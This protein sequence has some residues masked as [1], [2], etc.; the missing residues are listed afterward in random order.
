MH[1]KLGRV[2]HLS[3]PPDDLVARLSSTPALTRDAIQSNASRRADPASGIVCGV[4]RVPRVAPRVPMRADPVPVI[5][6]LTGGFGAEIAALVADEAFL[7]LDAPIARLTMRCSMG[8]PSSMPSLR[9]MFWRRSDPK[10]R[11][12][13]SSSER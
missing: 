1:E 10:I 7:D 3:E 13:S 12:R 2:E 8:T 4:M 6:E 5:V 9:M 11:I